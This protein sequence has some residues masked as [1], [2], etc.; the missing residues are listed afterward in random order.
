MTKKVIKLIEMWP[1]N[2]EFAEDI[3][4]KNISHC[5]TMKVRGRIPRAYWYPLVAA[6]KR[7]KLKGVTIQYLEE[8]HSGIGQR[9]S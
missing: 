9:R 8:I 6:A 3:G 1:S 4:L 7:R 2:R 5:R